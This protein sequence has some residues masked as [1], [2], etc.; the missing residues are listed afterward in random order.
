MEMPLKSEAKSIQPD[1]GEIARSAVLFRHRLEDLEG[2][3]TYEPSYHHYSTDDEDEEE[4]TFYEIPGTSWS[5]NYKSSYNV[6]NHRSILRD[7]GKYVEDGSTGGAD[8]IV[9]WPQ[10]KA[11]TM[12][13]KQFKEL[14]GVAFGIRD[15]Y[16]IYDEMDHSEVQ[17]D[18]QE[19][20]WESFYR[21]E[22]RDQLLARLN[23]FLEENLSEEEDLEL[24]QEAA[25]TM[26]E[27]DN[28][29]DSVFSDLTQYGSGDHW[30][31]QSDGDWYLNIDQVLDVES[32]SQDPKERESILDKIFWNE[33]MP[34]LSAKVKTYQDPRQMKFPFDVET[35]ADVVERLLKC[36][37][38]AEQV[39]PKLHEAARLTADSILEDHDYS[40]VMLP[41]PEELGDLIIGWGKRNIPETDL[42][43]DEDGLGRETEPHITVK[44]GLTD[45]MPDE[46]LLKVFKSTA[47]FDVKLLPISL[48]RSEK[49][50]VV[51]LDISSPQ[52][53]EL[54]RRVCD[55]APHHDTFPEYIPHVTIAYVKKGTGDKL[56]GL[57]PFD[58]E[59]KMGVSTIGKEGVF[60][61]EGVEFSSKLDAK[62]TYKL[63]SLHPQQ[64]AW[65]VPPE[66]V[67]RQAAAY[68]KQWEKEQAAAKQPKPPQEI[69]PADIVS[70][71]NILAQSAN[72]SSRKLSLIN[73]M[74]REN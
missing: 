35:A 69:T 72:L 31:E 20:S 74:V 56:E 67:D 9:L 57:S 10:R 53:L 21:K 4:E 42:F 22:F 54:N 41:L 19:E 44:Y 28:V 55:V 70:K 16:P 50:D 27:D 26:L 6:S 5:K 2:L 15:N 51:K 71:S 59:V 65:P 7:Y 62:H 25:D 64:E 24:A 30:D 61:A 39:A 18:L 23:D 13:A 46:N 47:P 48:F 49:Y 17:G 8:N 33:F 63:G 36:A 3:E 58:D 66:E 38:S 1:V 40:C 60:K 68:H 73:S 11:L 32:F 29:V 37:L 52:L 34:K 45:P 12:P 43:V 14:L